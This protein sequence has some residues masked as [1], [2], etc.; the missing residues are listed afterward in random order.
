MKAN[1]TTCG[2]RMKKVSKKAWYCYTCCSL[3]ETFAVYSLKT[4]KLTCNH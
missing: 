4:G 1:C 2:K 3:V